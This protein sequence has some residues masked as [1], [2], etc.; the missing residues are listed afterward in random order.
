MLLVPIAMVAFIWW[1]WHSDRQPSS[2]ATDAT[3]IM[4][5]IADGV[6]FY[7]DENGCFPGQ[8][9]ASQQGRAH[10]GSQM[11]AAV[12][13]GYSLDNVGKSEAQVSPVSM[14]ALYKE[15]SLAT[16][17]GMPMVLS[18]GYDEPMAICYYV[19]SWDEDTE[20]P[21][22]SEQNAT[23]TAG[24]P[25]QQQD[26]HLSRLIEECYAK[27]RRGPHGYITLSAG[28]DRTYFTDD[29]D[30]IIRMRNRPERLT[31]AGGRNGNRPD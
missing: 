5:T 7:Y 11:L 30:V 9:W 27:Y 8:E 3:W 14:Y 4:Q 31:F 15:D 25:K 17:D 2:E 16:I 19:F 20:P 18:D 22:L 28:K 10:T 26:D 1:P 24:K 6:D 29:D 23:H 12:M 21:A 13:F